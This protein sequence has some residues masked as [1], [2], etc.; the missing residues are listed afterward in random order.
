MISF[1]LRTVISKM[2]KRTSTGLT[3]DLEFNEELKSQVW[4]LQD[5]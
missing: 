4:D 3:T 1:Y 2:I 5:R